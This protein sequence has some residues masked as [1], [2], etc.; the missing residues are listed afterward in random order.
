MSRTKQWVTG[1]LSVGAMALLT[2]CGGTSNTVDGKGQSVV[3]GTTPPVICYWLEVEVTDVNGEDQGEETY[4]A[5]KAEW[6]RNKVGSTWVDA[7]GRQ[8]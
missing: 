1:A 4:C 2:A 6:D 7:N 3:P 8:R 5:T